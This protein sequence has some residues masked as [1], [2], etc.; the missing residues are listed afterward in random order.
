LFTTRGISG[1]LKLQLLS[2]ASTLSNKETLVL[3][4]PKILVTLIDQLFPDPA[5][6]QTPQS[7]LV[8]YI[9]KYFLEL[10]SPG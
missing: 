7:L 5:L 3:L 9:H 4:F 8:I 6:E 10:K 2:K 1:A